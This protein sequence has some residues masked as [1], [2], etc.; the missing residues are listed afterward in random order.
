MRSALLV[1]VLKATYKQG[2][3]INS[4]S[5]TSV[6]VSD[7]GRK[8]ERVVHVYDYCMHLQPLCHCVLTCLFFGGEG[9]LCSV[10]FFCSLTC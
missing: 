10:F 1:I 4:S 8:L 2:S 5:V 7:E 6:S 3:L 9:G